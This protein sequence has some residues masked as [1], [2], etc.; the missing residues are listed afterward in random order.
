MDLQWQQLLTH[1]VGFVITVWIL[2][3]FAWKPLLNLMEERRNRIAGEFD[4]IEQEKAK[5]AELTSE[6]EGK[7]RDID[8]ERRAKLVEAV[9]EGKKI[10]EEMKATAR[11]EAKDIV[12]KAKGE[13]ERD[14]AKARVQLKDDMIAATI[15]AAEKLIGERLDDAKH[16]EMIGRYIDDLEKA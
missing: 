3:K 14:V 11:D 4:E 2:K 12:T 15:T 1:L 16:R 7:L 8:N 9:N 6:Y 13:L 10:A 5:V